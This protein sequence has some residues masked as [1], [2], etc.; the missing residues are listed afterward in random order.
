[1]L[2]LLGC[3]LILSS[4]CETPFT[5]VCVRVR[6]FFSPLTKKLPGS[7]RYIEILLS[8]EKTHAKAVHV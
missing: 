6:M 4:V 3:L 8:K 2:Q 7:I 5:H 1:M